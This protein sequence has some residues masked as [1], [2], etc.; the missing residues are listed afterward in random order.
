MLKAKLARL[1]LALIGLGLAGIA[2]GRR[3]DGDPT[4][5]PFLLTL[6]HRRATP[7][8]AAR[9]A[10]PLICGSSMLWGVSTVAIAQVCP[11]TVSPSCVRWSV[12]DDTLHWWDLHNNCGKLVSVTYNVG[13]GPETTPNFGPGERVRV[14]VRASDPPSYVVWDSTDAM[15]FYRN[16]P[17]G[18]QLECLRSL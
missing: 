15:R 18:A 8:R 1:T 17:A 12:Y 16:R 9:F 5:L 11:K 2:V 14:T 3:R 6:S 7:L 4:R 10:L 13:A